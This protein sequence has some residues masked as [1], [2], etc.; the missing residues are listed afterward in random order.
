LKSAYRATTGGKFSEALSIFYNILHSLLFI[1]VDSK[2]EANEAKE[3]L[4]IC[5]EYLTGLRM[6]LQ[7][8]DEDPTR[9][10]ELAAY[11]THCNLQQIHLQLSL[12]SAM[13]CSYKIKNFQLAANFA[14]RLLELEPKSDVA[15]QARKVIMHA[16]TNN[17]NATPLNYNDKNPFVV[18]GISF[19]PIYKGNPAVNCPF[20][21][22]TF[23]PAHKGK[24]CPTCQV[25]QIG[26]ECSGLQ[27]LSA[28]QKTGTKE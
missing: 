22:G 12:R 28:P 11:F 17:E 23:L 4:G 26:K 18:C 19:T 5:R 10:A 9:Q 24:L 13:N 15:A 25:A 7:R 1:V 14:R 2:K 3:L 16:E 27:L 21:Q 20:C 8:K 6:E